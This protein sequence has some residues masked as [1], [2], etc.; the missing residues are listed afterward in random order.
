M[1]KS[2]KNELLM[3]QTQRNYLTQVMVLRF[4]TPCNDVRYKHFGGPCYTDLQGE[5][6]GQSQIQCHIAADG[7]YTHTRPVRPGLCSKLC[8]VLI[9]YSSLDTSV[10]C[11][12]ATSFSPLN[13]LCWASLWHMFRTITVS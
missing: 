7:L 6:I 13:F 9:Y 5:L 2:N 12:N 8:L 1:P 11:L 3:G 10:V 4:M